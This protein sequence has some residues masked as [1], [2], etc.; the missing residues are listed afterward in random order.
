MKEI[1]SSENQ[2]Y[3][4]VIQL[5]TKKFRDKLGCYLIEGPNLILEALNYDKG[6]DMVLFQKSSLF[7]DESINSALEIAQLKFELE[8]RGITIYS[9][10]DRIFSKLTSTETPQGVLG[11]VK[12]TS[13]DEEDFFHARENSN[14]NIIVLDRLQDPGNIG[15]I[16]RTADGA[17]YQGA[18]IL[19]GTADVFSPKVVRATTG[20]LFRL[21]MI[22]VDSPEIAID[23][24]K[25]KNKT[26]ICTALNYARNYYD[27]PMSHDT[28]VVIGNEGNGVCD[29][30][31]NN[32]DLRVKI[33]MH[34]S[35]ESLNA[36]VAAGI[37]IYESVRK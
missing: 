28:A 7:R 32:S 31:I 30:F 8:K 20:S 25:K 29:E 3:K 15:T 33:P 16:L 36:A 5:G 12:K 23:I 13:Y 18:M 21:P 10:E 24:L 37:L 22:F 35:I 19:K 2:I 27:C 4:K 14:G 9:V 34:S 6:L 17:G 26:V 1:S 11:V